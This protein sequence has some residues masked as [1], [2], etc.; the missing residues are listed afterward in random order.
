MSVWHCFLPVN[1][2]VG[3]RDVASRLEGGEVES[4]E[5]HRLYPELLAGPLDV[6]VMLRQG[7]EQLLFVDLLVLGTGFLL[8]HEGLDEAE[9]IVVAASLVVVS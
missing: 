2:Q 1:L 5:L 3:D 7:P 4:V 8:R 6:L 9:P